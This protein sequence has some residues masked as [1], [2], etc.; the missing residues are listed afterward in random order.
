MHPAIALLLTA[1]LLVILDIVWFSWSLDAVYKPAFLA[2]QGS[3]L[4]LRVAGG[5]LAWVLPTHCAA[6]CCLVSLST[7]FITRRTMQHCAAG[8]YD[9]G[10][11]TPHGER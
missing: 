7:G 10:W 1:L 5:A 8:R 11:S 6:V 3:P 2:T 9:S 4:D